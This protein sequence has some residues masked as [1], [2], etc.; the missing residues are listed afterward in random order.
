MTNEIYVGTFGSGLFKTAPK[1]FKFPRFDI[2]PD[3]MVPF[4]KVITTDSCYRSWKGPD[5]VGQEKLC[6]AFY[7]LYCDSGQTKEPT[8][9]EI[10][11]EMQRQGT[12]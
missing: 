11:A 3:E 7:K 5:C 12:A 4:G 10:Q 2:L 1:D 8:E 6:K 9:A